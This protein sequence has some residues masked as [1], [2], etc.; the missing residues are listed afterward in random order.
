MY[1]NLFVHKFKFFFMKLIICIYFR[2]LLTY[3]FI[4]DSERCDKCIDFIIM[5]FYLC[6]C[7]HDML[8]IE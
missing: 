7:L 5:C 3:L 4:L 6:V 8:L 1:G 2:P